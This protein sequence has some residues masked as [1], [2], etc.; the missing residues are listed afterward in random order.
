MLAIKETGI[1][2]N[3][4]LEIFLPFDFDDGQVEVFIVRTENYSKNA[5]KEK[6]R[7]ALD[8]LA[9]CENSFTNIDP[10][11]WQKEARK[12]RVLPGRE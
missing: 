1:V 5:K 3:H 2:K 10:M 9:K 11:D 7:I 8:E 4:K 6:L 12:D